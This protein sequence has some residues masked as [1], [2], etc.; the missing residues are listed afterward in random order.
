ALTAER[1]VPDPF[2]VP[3]ERLYRTGDRVRLLGDGAVEFLGRFDSQ[4]KIR[5]FRIEPGEV[6][7]V[8]A[9]AP[10]VESAVV[11]AREDVP[12][13]R[14]LVGYAVPQDEAGELGTAQLREYL[15]D[16]LPAYMVPSAFVV[17]ESF[18]LTA[19][20]KIDR[21]ALPAPEAGGDGS[22][23]PRT[24]TEQ[25]LAAIWQEVLE[26]PSVGALD[27]F[28]EVGGHSLLA[29]QVISR[30]RQAFDTDL[31]LRSLFENPTIAELAPVVEAAQRADRGE[32]PPPLVPVPR[33]EPLPLSF[34]QQRLWFID[35]LEPGGAAYN[36]P[37]PLKAEGPLDLA[38]VEAGLAAVVA[39]HEVLRSRVVT[40][41][42]QARQVVDDPDPGWQLPVVDL[43]GL[44]ASVREEETRRL[45]ARDAGG[46]FD[47]ARG[48]LLRATAL[49]LEPELHVVLFNMHHI[50]SDGWSMG[51]LVDEVSE[52]YRARREGRT[53]DLP[54]LPVQYGDFAVW[55]RSWLSGE[56]LERELGFWRQMLEGAPPVLELPLDRPR[57]AAR[58]AAGG[59]AHLSLP[60]AVQEGLRELCRRQ[61]ATLFMVT[62]AATQLLLSR[63]S[64]EEKVP[65]GMPIAGRN[66]LGSEN[67]I[68][69]FVNTL[70]LVGDLSMVATFTELV[71]QARERSLDAQAHQDV[72][73]ERLVEAVAP[74][75]DLS[76]SP[77]FQVMFALQSGLS[78]E[79]ALEGL[80]VSRHPVPTTEA[81]FDYGLAAVERQEGLRITTSYSTAL[82]DLSRIRRMEQAL[83]SILRKAADEPELSL[84]R[85][86]LL[87][88]AERQQVLEEWR[89]S[90]REAVGEECL[91]HLFEA[92]ARLRPEA[93]ALAF[94]DLRLTYCELDQR[95]EALAARLRRRGV[96]PES[97]V[98]MLVEPSVERIVG[99]LAVLKT[100]GAFVPL[101][102]AFPDERLALIVEDAH[103]ALVLTQADQAERLLALAG[104]TGTLVLDDTGTA[105][106]APL[107]RR[108]PAGSR[109]LAYVIYT[110]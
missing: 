32:A 27:N 89:W 50:V 40:V 46:A 109:G 78:S 31:P 17:L 63:L 71:A 54:E 102:P 74:P 87:A 44:P 68:G 3:G 90:G 61:G 99:V 10:G 104:G 16:R 65:V 37:M 105:E 25:L 9:K 7:A 96:G 56:A 1:F 43:R 47:L 45:A 81:Q 24:Q 103:L 58:S 94:R 4:V 95:A 66:T 108:H 36:M 97:L 14:R 51:L 98:G 57:S 86:P 2:G 19:N 52:L 75:R 28:F 70:V 22:R 69:F 35:Q 83:L 5:G 11:L 73:F 60:V 29:T 38:A 30:L 85:F 91:H 82:F 49:E 21:R 107:P 39:R 67:L 18:P 76:R 6:E 64:G 62:L 8:L 15:R 41:D 93:P 100:G 80:E 13:E 92:Q 42:G 79:M 110:S 12:G 59:D 20:G 72:P 48:P 23:A 77:I 34:A 33:E 101:D 106:A 26:L 53:P 88:E 84:S 55:Q